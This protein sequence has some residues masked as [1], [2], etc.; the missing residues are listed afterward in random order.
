[1]R[2]YFTTNLSFQW[3][4]RNCQQQGLRY[5]DEGQGAT[6]VLK[7][8]KRHHLERA[9]ETKKEMQSEK[10]A[11]KPVR[12]IFYA[13]RQEGPLKS[14]VEMTANLPAFMPMG[15]SVDSNIM[16][17]SVDNNENLLASISMCYSVASAPITQSQLCT[18]D[19]YTNNGVPVKV[20][21]NAHLE[22]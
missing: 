2:Q 4:P 8:A 9:Q 13:H 5:N 22:G 16:G 1:M 20:G 10:E 11:I 12:K 17:I 15:I 21:G 7:K 19:E 14:S 6:L 3:S 18:K